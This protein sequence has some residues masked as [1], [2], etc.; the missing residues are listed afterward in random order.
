MIQDLHGFATCSGTWPCERSHAGLL[1]TGQLAAHLKWIFGLASRGLGSPARSLCRCGMI[2]V[3]TEGLNGST[4]WKE[5]SIICGLVGS[6]IDPCMGVLAVVG[7]HTIGL[8]WAKHT[9]VQTERG[10]PVSRPVTAYCSV[11]RS[12]SWPMDSQ[13]VS[14]TY[15]HISRT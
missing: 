13:W 2:V 15:L 7:S 5:A 11:P 8:L 10:F 4:I 1:Q 12:A 14:A 9:A 6:P 3:K